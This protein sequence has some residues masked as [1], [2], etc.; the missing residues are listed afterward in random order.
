LSWLTS[1]S[2]DLIEVNAQTGELVRTVPNVQRDL[3]G[4]VYQT[5]DAGTTL[6]QLG[7]DGQVLWTKPAQAIFGP[8]SDNANYG[9]D[10]DQFGGLNVGTLG[11]SPQG[12]AYNFGE[13]T[14][15]AFAAS[16]GETKWTDPGMYNCEGPFEGFSHPVICDISGIVNGNASHPYAGVTMKIEGFDLSS[17]KV[18]WSRSVGDPAAIIGGNIPFID[19]SHIVIKTSSSYSV[20]DLATGS[21]APV[22]NQVFWCTS[23]PTEKVTAPADSGYPNF[24]TGTTQFFGCNATGKRLSVLPVSQPSLVGVTLAG[25]FFWTS[26]NGLKSERGRL[27][28]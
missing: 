8:V 23:S 13:E 22:R 12:Q 26:S 5:T 7:S 25:R 24:R 9:W 1:T 4:P 10:I 21:L 2:S 20:L 14:T 27:A 28:H 17:G 16:S 11:V 19:G 6:L 15:S 18:T 3:G